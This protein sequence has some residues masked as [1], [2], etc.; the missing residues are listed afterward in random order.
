M[1]KKQQFLVK[2]GI[3]FIGKWPTKDRYKKKN[4]C[5]DKSLWFASFIDMPMPDFEGKFHLIFVYKLC[6]NTISKL[7]IRKPKKKLLAFVRV[8]LFFFQCSIKDFYFFF[9]SFPNLVFL[10][11]EIPLYKTGATAFFFSRI[12]WFQVNKCLKSSQFSFD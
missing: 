10:S 11:Y 5:D 7:I 4:V 8:V 6:Y 9:W 12:V 2:I 1:R 3:F